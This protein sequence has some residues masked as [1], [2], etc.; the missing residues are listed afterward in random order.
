MSYLKNIKWEIVPLTIPAVIRNCPK[1]GNNAVYR[2]SGK[3][4]VN[5][6]KNK[7]DIWLIYQCEK[8][9]ST[10]NMGIYERI[11]PTD[12]DSQLYELFL[13]NDIELAKEYGF[14]I[15][16]HNKNKVKLDFT[17]VEYGI[18]GEDIDIIK[19]DFKGKDKII[20]DIICKYPL[21]LRVDKVLSKKLGI[22]R[23]KVKNLYENSILMGENNKNLLKQKINDR[24][25]IFFNG[26]IE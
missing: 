12:I 17:N 13:S 23:E 7:L 22:S 15:A 6:N 11:T 16:I 25:R 19:K 18:I 26:G 5:A 4:R 14:D 8:C 10:W 24:V 9:K 21:G 1:C 2:S 20:L 3:F